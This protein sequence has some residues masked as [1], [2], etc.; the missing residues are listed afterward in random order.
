MSYEDA[1][2]E[3]SHNKDGSRF[4][5]FGNDISIGDLIIINDAD[6][7]MAESV[8]FKTVPEFLNDPHL[9]FTQH[10]TK[11]LNEQRGESFYTNMLEVYTDALYQGHFLLSSIL[12]CH[13]PL[14]GHSIFLRSDAVKQCGR[15][16]TLRKTQ[17][18]LKNI[19]LPFVPI[20][21]VGATNL[22]SSE[23]TE[24]WS[25]N[26]VSEDFELMIHLYNLGYNGRYIAYPDCEFQEGITRTFDEE[27]GR[28]RKFALGAHELV[29]NPFNSWL[30]QGV[31]SEL[32]K[33]F[34]VSDIPSYYKVFLTSYLFSYTSGSVYILVFSLA[35][36]ARILDV[37]G[38]I[39]YLYAFNSATVL[40]LSFVI[41]YVIGYTCFVIAMVRMYINNKRML[42]REYRSKCWLFLAYKLVRYSLLFQLMFYSVMSNYFFLGGFDHM[43]SRSGVV[44][45][46]NKDSIKLTRCVALWEVIKFNSGSWLIAAYMLC[47]SYTVVLQNNSWDYMSIPD[48][49]ILYNAMFVGP[50]AVMAIMA[51]IIP[52]IMNPY[53]LGW[54]FHPSLFSPCFKKQKKEK[55]VDLHTFMNTVDPSKALSDEMARIQGKPDI[56]VG[57]LATKD[58]GGMTV[59]SPESSQ[60]RRGR[61]PP[62]PIM[63]DNGPPAPALHQSRS[64]AAIAL[65][66]PTGGSYHSSTPST[67]P[68]SRGS[69]RSGS[70]RR[71]KRS[72]PPTSSNSS[73]PGSS[74]RFHKAAI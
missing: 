34:L 25:E 2:I 20:D 12:G 70:Q 7:R 13:P 28:H 1:L 55:V 69:D 44:S 43:F 54:P 46:T 14:V 36:I 3:Q 5:M 27:A 48:N 41:Y 71:E 21:Q 74:V 23:S 62:P 58:V 63:T 15:T 18:W 60:Q 52:V 24:F 72:S 8:I 6:A 31:F 65:G 26:H 33:T 73:I 56:E 47:L 38:E 45:A 35:A 37:E 11:T 51:F 50:A 39:G 29:F 30:G 66:Q 16:R 59:S 4:V 42:F 57:S 22:Q 19:G 61:R 32:F 40:A 68:S 53:V 17:R 64:P 49:D 67:Q 10:T 9:G